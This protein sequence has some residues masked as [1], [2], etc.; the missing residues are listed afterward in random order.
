MEVAVYIAMLSSD[1]PIWNLADIPITDNGSEISADSRFDIQ[2]CSL[3]STYFHSFGA[4]FPIN[5]SN[6]GYQY[7]F[8]N[9]ADIRNQYFWPI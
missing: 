8:C 1:A 7:T 5:I 4:N 2:L 9:I 6:F 3:L